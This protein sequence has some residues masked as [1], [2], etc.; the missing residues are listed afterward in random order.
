MSA[1]SGGGL[2]RVSQKALSSSSSDRF[3][4]TLSSSGPLYRE[5]V[6]AEVITEIVTSQFLN[7]EDKWNLEICAE[8]LARQVGGM[9]SLD[10]CKVVNSF[11]ECKMIYNDDIFR[12]LG[13]F[14]RKVS[15]N[16]LPV[17]GLLQGIWKN[18]ESQLFLLKCVA[19]SSGEDIDLVD[20][21]GMLSTSDTCEI[22]NVETPPNCSWMCVAL[23]QT[24]LDLA[25][26]GL[27][28]DVGKVL[29]DAAERYPEHAIIALAR[30]KS[31]G[32]DGRP[33]G[34]GRP[35]LREEL[36]MRLAQA[37]SGLGGSRPTSEAMMRRIGEVNEN[38]L[39]WLLRSSFKRCTSLG[40]V[41]KIRAA[42]T[43]TQEVYRRVQ[44]EGQPDE[45]LSL[46]CVMHDLYPQA[47]DLEQKLSSVLSRQ[48]GF[49]RPFAIFLRSHGPSLRETGATSGGVLSYANFDLMI[50]LLQR[51]PAQVSSDEIEELCLFSRKA[52]VAAGEDASRFGMPAPGSSGTIS[53]REPPL[54]TVESE[55]NEHFMQLYKGQVTVADALQLLQRF[56]GSHVQREQEVF[57]CMLHNLFD[58]Y[59]FYQNYPDRELTLTAKLFGGLVARQLVSSITLGIALRYVLESLRVEGK[60]AAHASKM[61]QF[62][63]VTIEQFRARLGEWPQYCTHLLQISHLKE[64]APHLHRDATVAISNPSTLAA[65]VSSSPSDSVI[66]TAPTDAAVA[67]PSASTGELD[68][69][70]ATAISAFEPNRPSLSSPTLLSV[71]GLSMENLNVINSASP[72]GSSADDMFNLNMDPLVDSLLPLNFNPVLTPF[73]GR[74]CLGRDQRGPGGPSPCLRA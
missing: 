34:E 30:C 66:T 59:R 55:S 73:Q 28:S 25:E 18:K 7:C 54:D 43:V 45:L 60:G 47:M 70:D 48:P 17:L 15:G 13:R 39:V 63:V 50:E 46:W 32:L 20:F 33:R 52:K 22:E 26:A 3:M 42:A 4:N 74:A 62:G 56:K 29:L 14:F 2:S 67:A 31:R 58:E 36:L 16:R 38:L 1:Q 64:Y 23:Y 51:Y 69:Y 41:Q 72:G 11:G 5:E 9:R 8:V 21:S 65:H 68:P 40:E 61:F 6:M 44:N 12:L 53:A 57:R 24:L 19:N 71:D 27:W 49:A 10:W 35:G 37:F